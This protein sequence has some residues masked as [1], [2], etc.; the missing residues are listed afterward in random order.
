NVTAQ[1]GPAHQSGSM[2]NRR[3]AP[4]PGSA[5]RVPELSRQCRIRS[6][7]TQKCSSVHGH[8]VF[9]NVSIHDAAEFVIEEGFL[10]QR[11]PD[12]P[13]ALSPLAD[14][15]AARRGSYFELHHLPRNGTYRRILV[16]ATHCGEG[17]FTIR[18]ADLRHV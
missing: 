6:H 2:A 8:M 12:A 3:P 15:H 13:H 14:C 10:L 18:L 7:L 16:V 17:P 11:H 9:G 4:R 5:P 1:V